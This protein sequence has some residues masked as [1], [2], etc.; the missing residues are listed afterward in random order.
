[1]M[2]AA[3][4]RTNMV[5]SQLRP[6]KVTDGR[7][8]AAFQAIPRERF[9]PAEH[10]GNAYVDDDLPL[11]DGRYLMEP[12]AFARLVQ[13]ADIAAGDKILE[14]GSG[15]GYGAAILA[16]LGASVVAVERDPR[17]AAEAERLL[18]LL[19]IGNV[20]VVVGPVERG[21]GEPGAYDVIVL[22]GAAAEIPDAILGQLAVGGRLVYI[23]LSVSGGLGAATL[24][25]RSEGG[26]NRRLLFEAGVPALPG[27]EARHG[28]VF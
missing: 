7:V 4:I 10:A 28:F 16:R 9:V 17:L 23:R 20:T 14:I 11:G 27:L 6:N 2:P 21:H 19:G 24:I 22:S 8:L 3:Q 26:L 18:G 13:A 15:T 5:E 1:M 25:E 12:V